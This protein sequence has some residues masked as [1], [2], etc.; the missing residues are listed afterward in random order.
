MAIA[1][2]QQQRHGKQSSRSPSVRHAL[3]S[4]DFDRRGPERNTDLDDAER[5][6]LHRKRRVDDAEASRGTATVTP[7]AAGTDTFTL[8]CMET[9]A[10]V[11]AYSMG[12][13]SSSSTSASATLTVAPASTFSFTSLVSDT[14]GTDALNT[15][16][17]LTNPWGIVLGPGTPMWV[18]DNHSQTS[19]LY[20]G[21]G[22]AQPTTGPLVVSLPNATGNVAFDPTGI[23]FNT[24]TDFVV[25]AAGISGAAK[26]IFSGEGA[27]IAG[28]SPTVN[29]T[30][31]ITMY[32]DTGGA[33]YKG[34]AIAANGAANVLYATDFHNAKID[35]FDATYA[36]Q[37]LAAGKFVDPS[38][39]SGYSPFGIQAVNNGAG[40]TWQ[41]YVTYALPQP[42]D[43][44]VNM[45]G[46]GLGLIDIYD[47]GGTFV[48]RLVSPGGALNAPWG[49]APT[50]PDFG[51]L[52]NILLVGNFGDGK[53]NGYDPSSGQWIGT[54]IDSPARRSPP[55][56]CGG[57]RS[58]TTRPISRTTRCSTQPVP[59]DEA[60]GVYGRIDL[61]AAPT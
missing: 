38:L 25:S 18:A 44:H 6:F 7:T 17:H 1:A 24:T 58:A 15:D 9:A 40:G 30:S 41:I 29:R 57:L 5:R 60:N 8:T 32:T 52:S 19:T 61:G 50:P 34:L 39:P 43:N 2:Q 22:K 14:S 33:V 31:A 42:P 27:M 56:A 36:K 53:I 54:V 16:T 47:A 37:T 21:A 45:S 46:A 28:W 35:L 11:G 23:V 20:D 10:A 26:F 12:A 3:H 51:T 13:P 55:R 4:A 48:K 49:L 59:N